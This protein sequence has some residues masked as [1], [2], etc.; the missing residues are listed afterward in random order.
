MIVL[1][2]PALQVPANGVPSIRL[3]VLMQDLE[4]VSGCKL[5]FEV[6]ATANV[7]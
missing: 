6:G 4:R 2:V 3:H 7:L 1:H 5:D